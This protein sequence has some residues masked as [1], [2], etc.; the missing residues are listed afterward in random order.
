VVDRKTKLIICTA[1]ASG[2]THDFK[3][4][5]DSRTIINKNILAL[6]DT[7]YIGINK[8][9]SYS[10]SPKRKSKHNPLTEQDKTWNAEI[11]S[12]RV[13]C[14]NVIGMLKRFKILALK[15]RNHRK[16]FELRF[17]L[18]AGFHNFEIT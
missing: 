16:R 1:F 9:H 12:N 5:K 18:I 17:N 13:L 2:K 14:E 8:F 6:V 15:Y 10:I 4:F 11:S 7:G 3:L